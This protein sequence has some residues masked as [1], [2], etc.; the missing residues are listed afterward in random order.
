M[1]TRNKMANQRA[2]LLERL[3]AGPLSSDDAR[4]MGITQP[5]ARVWELRNCMNHNILTISQGKGA[6]YV[7]ASGD[8]VAAA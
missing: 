8:S 5:S 3:K 7:L 1:T 4:A 2:Q 6:V